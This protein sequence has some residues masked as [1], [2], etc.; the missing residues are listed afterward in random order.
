MFLIGLIP[1]FYSV[2][3]SRRFPLL[4]SNHSAN[5]F[6]LL[7]LITRSSFGTFRLSKGIYFSPGA[8]YNN[9]LNMLNFIRIDFKI[10][11]I[12]LIFLGVIYLFRN[13][14]DL[15][16]FFLINLIIT[17]TFFAYASFP[18]GLDYQLGTFEKYLPTPY[19]Y[20][21][22]LMVFG[23]VWLVKIIDIIINN[24]FLKTVSRLMILMALM[25]FPLIIFFNNYQKILILKN[26]FTAE[27][28]GR[29]ILASV[30]KN[31]IV[32]LFDDTSSYNTL[33]VRYVLKERPDVR[34]IKFDNLKNSFYRQFIQKNYPD[35]YLPKITQEDKIFLRKFLEVNGRKYPVLNSGPS[36]LVDKIWLPNGLLWRYYLAK[37]KLPS[38]KE[39]IESNL[40]L[41]N[42]F[43]YPLS[44]SLSQYRSLLLAD[45]LRVYALGHQSFGMML[46]R[47]KQYPLAENEFKDAINYWPDRIDNYT[48]L[49]KI[50]IDT[51][52][53]SQ[54]KKI[55]NRAKKI[56]RSKLKVYKYFID[57]YA[58][59]YRD[60]RKLKNYL[61][62]YE[63]YEKEKNR[64]VEKI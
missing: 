11:G 25:V 28:L 38:P 21:I 17:F 7:K 43:H 45:V 16:G 5:P 41:W 10:F 36:A 47:N 3:V 30:P 52:K 22:F 35:I 8:A 13:K 24:L 6:G 18:L 40:I 48:N 49:A 46:Y 20:L 44:G 60:E 2:F 64:P 34:I 56:G 53:C 42:S 26:D 27:N 58:N 9:V 61:K 19:L 33:Y 31:G 29:D 63:K 4:D 14:K 1:Y 32:N 55:L 23:G 57:L 15:F 50:Y 39:L 59:C 12:V 54:G 62:L 51:K 37:S